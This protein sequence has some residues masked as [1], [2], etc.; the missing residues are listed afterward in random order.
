M[1]KIV[2]MTSDALVALYAEIGIAPAEALDFFETARF[3][4]LFDQ[5]MAIVNELRSHPGDERRLLLSLY[6]H[7]NRQVRLNVAQSTYMLN[8][9]AAHAVLEE[10]A[11]SRWLPQ[12][13]NAGFSLLGIAEGDSA[14]LRD[15]WIPAT[16]KER[17]ELHRA[18]MAE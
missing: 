1:K 3:N 16:R 8:R 13:A 5:E 9:A 14:L 15:P 12:S 18:R 17:L 11:A 10:I 6:G 2:V 7:P 4:R